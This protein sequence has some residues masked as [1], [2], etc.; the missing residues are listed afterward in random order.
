MK[1]L[2][3]NLAIGLMLSSFPGSEA[4]KGINH[5]EKFTHLC[6]YN[7]VQKI[8]EI[9]GGWPWEALLPHRFDLFQASGDNGNSKELNRKKVQ[10]INVNRRQLHPEA[11]REHRKEYD[12]TNPYEP[13]P[14][15]SSEYVSE[16][17]GC[18]KMPTALPK[19]DVRKKLIEGPLS[20]K[21][22]K[23]SC[24]TKAM[25]QLC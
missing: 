25:R 24:T 8:Y 16:A 21:C 17:E 6:G 3:F 11:D 20:K 1:C 12:D 23:T 10:T 14:D 15:D 7:Y 13:M 18:S 5:D 2:L 9:C 4:V 22:C 19:I